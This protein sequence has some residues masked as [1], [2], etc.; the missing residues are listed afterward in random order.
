MSKRERERESSSRLILSSPSLAE[1]ARGWVNSHS[2]TQAKSATA[3][4]YTI[5]SLRA[6]KKTCVAIHKSKR[7]YIDC[8]ANASAFARKTRRSR[9][10]FSNDE[11]SRVF[12][13]VKD[14]HPQTPLVLREGALRKANALA[15]RKVA[16]RKPSAL[17]LSVC[18]K[19]QYNNKISQSA[20]ILLTRKLAKS[21]LGIGLASGICTNTAMAICTFVENDASS[22]RDVR[23]EGAITSGFTGSD[24]SGKAFLTTITQTT[25][26]RTT[27]YH[28][29]NANT[30]SYIVSPSRIIAYFK[31]NENDSTDR[32]HN[33]RFLNVSAP[34]TWFDFRNEKSGADA[35]ITLSV[36]VGAGAVV[37]RL[38]LTGNMETLSVFGSGAYLGRLES[39]S[40]TTT[41]TIKTLRLGERTTINGIEQGVGNALLGSNNIGI[42][43]E[44]LELDGISLNINSSGAV[45]NNPKGNPTTREQHLSFIAGSLTTHNVK[46]QS[47]IINIGQGAQK[48]VEYRYENLILKGDGDDKLTGINGTHITA[49]QGVRLTKGSDGFFL[50][51]DVSTSQGS[52][53]YRAL[54]LSY[55]R[56]S[57]MTQNI[58][59]TMT[60]K[61]FHSDRY[62]EQE[63]Q[64]KELKEDM[65]RLTN[66]SKRFSKLT[67]SKN[68]DSIDKVR[69]KV[70]KLTLEQ[71]RAQNLKKY[72]NFELIDQL[73]AMFIPYNGRRDNRVFVLPYSAHSYAD[74]GSSN[75]VEWVGGTLVGLQKNLRAAGIIGG[76]VGY[77]FV[78]TSTK[79]LGADT[80]IQTNALQAGMHYFKSFAFRK[81]AW[82]GFIKGNIRGGVDFPQFSMQ[83]AGQSVKLTSAS[84][85][86]KVPLMWSV[87]AEMRTGITFY[88][89]KYNSYVAPEIGVSYDLLSSID[90]AMKKP[91]QIGADELHNAISWHLPQ[92]SFSVRYYKMW[93][94]VFR[95]SVKAGVRYNIFSTQRARFSIGAFDDNGIINLP[96]GYGN[97]ALDFIWLIKKNHELSLGYDGLFYANKFD[98]G[99]ED[100]FNGITTTLNLKYAY[101]FGSK[102]GAT[103][104]IKSK[105]PKSTKK[106]KKPKEPK[107]E[108][109][110]ESKKDAKAKKEMK[111]EAKK[112]AKAESKAKSNK[113]D[114]KKNPKKS[115]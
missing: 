21:L 114:T 40:S 106:E 22:T 13:S 84:S 69:Q 20:F 104:S 79:L 46:P 31:K 23:C 55:M 85:A 11:F 81:R 1:G 41:T 90:M 80:K 26:Y 9:S 4:E 109:K 103:P 99:A 16:L 77:E 45:W 112:K 3:S 65:G 30:Y 97:L 48:G 67:R 12:T 82:E 39:G 61:T 93:G 42:K 25:Q 8:H 14:T 87:G 107:K 98:K 60:T 2:K 18:A 56:R 24:L 58:L 57:V 63:A 35:P 59:D 10:F 89:Y 95:T 74:M 83:V 86:S 62:Y 78:N 53:V 52:S 101:W 17:A 28:I 88:Q 100:R 113:K 75:A 38:I 115:K 73:D 102:A 76:Y 43:V 54:A 5:P 92:A 33:V 7:K 68:Q 110:K 37:G 111:K 44:R 49:G 72:N 32:R 47:I 51:A 36:E 50:Q 64:L 19:H 108:V 91:V 34:N 66:S 105:K 15:L 94:E 96:I 27:N 6:S 29:G 70:A 71:S